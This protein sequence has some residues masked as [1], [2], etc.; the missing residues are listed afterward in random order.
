M[1]K[2]KEDQNSSEEK[3]ELIVAPKRIDLQNYLD[4]LS[5]TRAERTYYERTYNQA[6]T[7]KTYEEWKT[8]IK[9]VH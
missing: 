1:A 7:L 5:L 6:Q 3:D 2:Q 9:I 4:N 8:E